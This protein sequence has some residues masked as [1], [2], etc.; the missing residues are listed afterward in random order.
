[1]AKTLKKAK[2][3]KNMK[4]SP[5]KRSKTAKVKKKQLLV[6][7]SSRFQR[8]SRIGQMV[9][10]GVVFAA[11]GGGYYLYQTL[12]SDGLPDGANELVVSYQIGMNHLLPDDAFPSGPNTTGLLLYGNGLMVCSPDTLNMADMS[13]EEMAKMPDNGL[14]QRQLTR[15]EVHALV[16]NLKNSGFNTAEAAN[17]KVVPIAGR[18]HSILVNSTEGATTVYGMGGVSNPDGFALAES[19]L[20]TE[21][22]KATTTFDPDD[23]YAETITLSSDHPDAKTATDQLPVGFDVDP[24]ANEHKTKNI[25]GKE[26]KALKAEAS[27]GSKVYTTTDGKIVRARVVPKIPEYKDP[28]PKQQS[29]KGKVSAAALYKVRFV[30]VIPQD[31]STPAWATSATVQDTANSIRSWYYGKTGKYFDYDSGDPINFKV[32]RGSK[33]TAQYLSCNTVTVGIYQLPCSGG[34][35]GVINNMTAEFH[36]PGVSTIILSAINTQADALGWGIQGTY[37]DSNGIISNLGG[38]GVAFA[39]KNADHYGQKRVRRTSAHELGHNMGAGHVCSGTLMWAG[40]SC[41]MYAAWND[42]ALAA[43]QATN[44]KTYSKFLNSPVTTTPPPAPTCA[45]T[46]L[47]MGGILSAGQTIQSPDCG[48]RFVMQTDGNLVVYSRLGH[49]IWASGSRGSGA[50]LALQTDSN[51]VIRDSAGTVKWASGTKGTG[52]N[53]LRVQNDGN[54]VLYSSSGAV[55]STHTAGD[56]NK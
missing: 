6:T 26:A 36:K 9:V 7:V 56:Y 43:G 34:S 48:I 17:S 47:G 52:G 23:V 30:A 55:W 46:T 53:Q 50:R 35:S 40:G 44:L 37:D 45:S 22:T 13:T 49:A 14:K 16:D 42:T 24:T 51:L 12:A 18:A 1:M 2:G 27:H 54:V 20:K 10:F 4:K 8:L 15:D 28:E 41:P 11:I 19:F 31:V 29:S 25:T 32:V 39:G 3:S 21:C 5:V 38:V 33:T